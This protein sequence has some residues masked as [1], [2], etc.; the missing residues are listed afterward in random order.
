MSGLF[1]IPAGRIFGIAETTTDTIETAII[2]LLNAN[3]TLTTIIAGR[4]FPNEIPQKQ[5][6]PAAAYKQLTSDIDYA[7]D[8]ETGLSNSKFEISAWAKT[9]AEVKAL[10]TAIIVVLSAYK[11]TINGVEIQGIFLVDEKDDFQKKD[12]NEIITRHGRV[13]TFEIWYI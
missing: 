1:S 11:G 6:M 13:M 9:Y 8:G 3:E 7:N 12:G 4:I 10:A 2:A 5:A